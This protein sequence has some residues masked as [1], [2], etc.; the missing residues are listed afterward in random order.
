MHA[1]YNY[2]GFADLVCGTAVPRKRAGTGTDT[3]PAAQSGDPIDNPAD[4]AAGSAATL[5][6]S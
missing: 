2:S 1:V 3:T 5:K 6:D 4:D